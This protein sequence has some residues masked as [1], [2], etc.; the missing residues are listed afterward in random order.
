M[1]EWPDQEMQQVAFVEGSY[2]M[3]EEEAMPFALEAHAAAA[4]LE[5]GGRPDV[6]RR[7]IRCAGAG[8]APGQAAARP[9]LGADRPAAHAEALGTL[10][11]ASRATS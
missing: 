1:A 3:S 7:D 10:L 9:G 2:V 6:C 8:A 11:A 4:A 5:M